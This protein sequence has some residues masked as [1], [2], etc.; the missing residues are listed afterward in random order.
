MCEKNL[1]TKPTHRLERQTREG[2]YTVF[3]KNSMRICEWKYCTVDE[4]EEVSV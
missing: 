2:P 4:G 1:Q 3:L